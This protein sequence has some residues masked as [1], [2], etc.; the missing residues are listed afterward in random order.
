MLPLN[1]C[2]NRTPTGF[3]PVTESADHSPHLAQGPAGASLDDPLYY[4]H[5]FQWLLDWVMARYS[6]LLDTPECQ[7]AQHFERLPEPSRALLVRMIM[8]KGELFRADRLNYPEIGPISPA[9]EPIIRLGLLEPAPA[10]TLE[11]LFALFTWPELRTMLADILE[12]ARVPPRAGKREALSIL[13][14]QELAPRTAP[15]WGAE[16]LPVYQLRVMPLADR[17][18]WLFFGNPYQ[19]W[20]EFVLTELG[21]FEYEPVVFDEA[22]RPVHSRQEL[23]QYWRLQS[24]RQQLTEGAPLADIAEA[25]PRVNPENPWLVRTRDRLLFRLGREWERAGELAL[26]RQVYAASGYPGTR[27]RLLRVLERQGAFEPAWH[28][29]ETAR[30]DP[31]SEAEAQQLE[32]VMPR[33]RRKLGLPAQP[34]PKPDAPDLMELLLPAS[35]PPPPPPPPGKHAGDRALWPAVLGCHFQPGERCLFPPLPARSCGSVLAGFLSPS[36]GVV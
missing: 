25:I 3:P 10:M 35:A 7:F 31:Q 23:Q 11:Q 29:A 28:L 20:S 16:A 1:R 12:A 24:C 36:S 2:I 32:R 27:G 26:A 22:S 17:F 5:N 14:D 15:E 19:D 21:L 6:D 8:R 13:V 9:A 4:L 18:R 33:L 34:R 30:R